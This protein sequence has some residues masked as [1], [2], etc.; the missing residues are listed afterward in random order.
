MDYIK[1]ASV[2]CLIL[3]ATNISLAENGD[4]DESL[5]SESQCVETKEGI[6]VFLAIADYYWK[7]IEKA[8][9]NGKEADEKLF[10]V[11]GFHAQQ[12]ANYS[13][14]YNDWCD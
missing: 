10:T 9:E 3:F 14:I 11:A 13:V 2:I 5:L 8:A 4:N 12:A 6:K 7:E 1:K